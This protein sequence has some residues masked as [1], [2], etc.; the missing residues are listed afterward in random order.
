VKEVGGRCIVAAAAKEVGA[1][2]GAWSSLIFGVMR[3]EARSESP[4][5]FSIH[6]VML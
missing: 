4:R 5:S 2:C 3:E 1:S 6:G